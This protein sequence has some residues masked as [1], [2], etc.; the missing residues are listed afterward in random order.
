MGQCCSAKL[1]K[2]PLRRKRKNKNAPKRNISTST[3]AIS[4]FEDNYITMPTPTHKFSL[5]APSTPN[6]DQQVHAD[7]LHALVNHFCD[8]S[9]STRCPHKIAKTPVRKTGYKVGRAMKPSPARKRVL[10]FSSPREHSSF[11]FPGQPLNSPLL[12]SS[13]LTDRHEL[14]CAV[15]RISQLSE[16]SLPEFTSSEEEDGFWDEG[17]SEVLGFCFRPNSLE[18]EMEKSVMAWV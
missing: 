11:L 5:P 4:F 16:S 9:F 3:C 15:H 14:T 18:D 6:T 10:S 17:D 1:P 13:F 2:L 8:C 12:C 7:M